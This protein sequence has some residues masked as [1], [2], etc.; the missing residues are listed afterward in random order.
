MVQSQDA[1][2]GIWGKLARANY[3]LV[4]LNG[5]SSAYLSRQ[6]YRISHEREAEGTEHVFRAYI[7]EPLPPV[8]SPLIG[9]CVQNMRNALDHLAWQ[10]VIAS[11]VAQPRRGTGFPISK[12]AA[13]FHDARNQIREMSPAIRA[14]IERVQPYQRGDI[15]RDPLWV[16]NELARVDRHRTLHVVTST[17]ESTRF[18]WGRRDEH[19]VFSVAPVPFV[20][21]MYDQ[22]TFG[23]FEDGAEIA[24]FVLRPAQPEMDVE[25]QFVIGIAFGDGSPAA[26][27]PIVESLAQIHGWLTTTLMP[28]FLPF[29]PN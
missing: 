23:P 21:R 17:H 13:A 1:L 5:E 8:L 9:D 3:H 25:C 6:P 24:R 2:E 12:D 18:S 29:F 22:I 16:L 14:A 27:F 7:T 15:D 4:T 20:E 19:G 28:E 10:L 11:G 26:R